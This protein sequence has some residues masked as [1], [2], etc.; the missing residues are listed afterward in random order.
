MQEGV[1][2]NYASQKLFTEAFK[3]FQFNLAGTEVK[4]V[5]HVQIVWK[6]MEVQE[7]IKMYKAVIL[8]A[9]VLENIGKVAKISRLFPAPQSGHLLWNT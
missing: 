2:E 8:F 9:K 5:V 7:C 6:A 1:Y 3:E 4:F